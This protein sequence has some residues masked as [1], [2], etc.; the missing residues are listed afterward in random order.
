MLGSSIYAWTASSLYGAE[1][2]IGKLISRYSI[3][4]PLL[5]NFIWSAFTFFLMLPVAYYYGAGVPSHWNALVWGSLFSA[6]GSVTYVIA[7]YKLDVSILGPLFSFRVAIA[8]LLGAIFLSEILTWYQ[9]FFIVVIFVCGLF[10][11]MDERMSVRSFFTTASAIALM[12]MIAL[13]MTAVFTKIAVVESGFWTT[14][15][16][17]SGLHLLFSAATIPFFKLSYKRIKKKEYSMIILISGVDVVANVAAVKAY[18]ISVSIATA[19]ISI[20]FSM[21]A[22]IIL[23][24][25]MPK[26]LERHTPRVYAIRIASAAI[27]FIAALQL[28]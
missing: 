21:I 9:Y 14:A 28:S 5:F 13:A 6:I 10:V 18:S 24:F 22:A 15:I 8:A 20:P 7:L 1:G 12:S 25:F 19:I 26:L 3:S 16:W 17:I 27:M 2:I 4:D 11:S 23:A